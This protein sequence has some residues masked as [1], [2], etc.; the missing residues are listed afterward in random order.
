MQN[1][2][3]GDADYQDICTTWFV[4][5]ALSSLSLALARQGCIQYGDSVVKSFRAEANGTKRG[6]TYLNLSDRNSLFF[7]CYFTFI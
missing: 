3:L 4:L 6:G 1:K 5:T 7:K 2:T